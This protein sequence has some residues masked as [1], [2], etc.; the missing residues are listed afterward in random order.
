MAVSQADYEKAMAKS[1]ASTRTSARGD[2]GYTGISNNQ[3]RGS[4]TPSSTSRSGGGLNFGSGLLS[5]LGG[6]YAARQMRKNAEENRRW[7]AEQNTLAYERSLPWSSYGPAGNVE[8]DPETKK[9]MQT[10]A[11]E[12]QDLM[13]Q[14]LGVAGMAQQEM[15]SMMGDPYKMEREQ[16][17][18]FEDFNRDAY[19]QSRAQGQ[20]AAIARGMQGT[21]SYYDQMAIEDAIGKDRMRG[22]LAAMGTG[23]DYRKMVGEEALGFGA[24]AQNVAG[25]LRPDINYGIGA[26]QGSEVAAN[27]LGL[28]GAGT[29]LTDTQNAYYSGMLGQGSKYG[30]STYG[31]SAAGTTPQ[32]AAGNTSGQGGFWSML[33][34][35]SSALFPNN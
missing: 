12:F 14:W 25:M 21:E 8:F 23:M 27:M 29:D 7:Q 31:A 24:G 34:N 35:V 3:A 17:K 28:S 30:A 13:G 19:A 20:E 22:Q 18:R 10:L 32:G 33:G 15:L 11:P 6:A 9:I 4:G 1:Y 16:F 5:S 26:G 2:R